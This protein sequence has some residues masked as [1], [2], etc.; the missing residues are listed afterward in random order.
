MSHNDIEN[1]IKTQPN[2]EWWRSLGTVIENDELS[3]LEQKLD[4][5]LNLNNE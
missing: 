1:R 3:K 5:I 4:N 2:E